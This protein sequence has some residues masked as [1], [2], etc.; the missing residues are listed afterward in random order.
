M[1]DDTRN[2]GLP[3]T[4]CPACERSFRRVGRSVYCSPSCRQLAFRFRHRQPDGGRL[5]ELANILRRQRRLV[6]QTVYEC[7]AC[8][9]RFLGE[10]RCDQC[11]LLSRKVGLG[12]RCSGCDEILT[13]IDL[14]GVELQGGDALI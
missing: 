13:V 10:R 14:I 4:I 2:D 5:A 12:G 3:Q 11:N 1:C 9:E 7:S 6:G 8:N